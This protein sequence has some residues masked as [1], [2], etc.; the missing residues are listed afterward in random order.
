MGFFFYFMDSLLSVVLSLDTLSLIYQLRKENKCDPKD[1]SRVSLTWILF[2][3]LKTLFTC[4]GKGFLCNLFGF[5]GLILKVL[6]VIPKIGITPKIH[7]KFIEEKKGEQLIH[8]AMDFVKN[9]FAAPAPPASADVPT[10]GPSDTM[11]PSDGRFIPETTG[12]SEGRFNPDTMETSD[13][14]FPH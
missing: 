8:T 14:R 7:K 6:I 10:T 3:S 12:T 2:L 11:G 13:G 9:K 1:Y 5:I 4:S